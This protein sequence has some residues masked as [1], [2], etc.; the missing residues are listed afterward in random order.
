MT[1]FAII[2]TTLLL[3][4]AQPNLSLPG[5]IDVSGVVVEEVSGDPLTGA[6]IHISGYEEIY[7]TDFEGRFN[8]NDL[9]SGKYDI[10]IEY[11]SFDSKVLKSI[12]IDPENSQLFIS[13]K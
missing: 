7:Y 12:Q 3:D 1:I 13:L 2:L 8:I 11:I 9:V 10:E 4:P 6:S 5:T